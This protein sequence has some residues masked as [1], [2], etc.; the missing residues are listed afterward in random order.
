MR[1]LAPLFDGLGYY[2]KTIEVLCSGT[3]FLPWVWAPIKLNLKVLSDYIDVFEKI[4][5][6]YFL[7]AKPLIRFKLLSHAYSKNS[8]I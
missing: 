6:V 5:K 1:R 2:S 4:I 8:D 7:I 3:P